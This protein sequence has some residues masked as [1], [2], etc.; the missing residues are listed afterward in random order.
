MVGRPCKLCR[1]R[2]KDNLRLGSIETLGEV[3]VHQN[4]LY[5]SSNLC[6]RGDDDEGIYG[7][8]EDDIKREADRTRF[9]QC[10]FCSKFGA[11]I[12]CCKKSCHKTF[13]TG[14]GYDNGV[15]YQFYGTY[16]AY[17]PKHI[18]MHNFRPGPKEICFIC[19][20]ALA[21]VGE[22][23]SITTMIFSPC[24]GNGWYHRSCL[25]KYA[26]SAGYFFKCPLCNDA[27]KFHDVARWGITIQN[28]DASWELEPGAFRDQAY[29]P[30]SCTAELC[31]YPRGRSVGN[32]KYCCLCGGNPIHNTCN[33]PKSSGT[34]SCRDCNI[35]SSAKP[36]NTTGNETPSD[37]HEDY[38]TMD[39]LVRFSHLLGN[40]NGRDGSLHESIHI[41]G[42]K[43]IAPSTEPSSDEDSPA[44]ST[45]SD[46][47][48]KKSRI[49][50][51]SMETKST[52]SLE[53]NDE[54]DP[55][56]LYF[57]HSNTDSVKKQVPVDDISSDECDPLDMEFPMH[58]MKTK[59]NLNPNKCLIQNKTSS[60]TSYFCGDDNKENIIGSTKL[61]HAQY[62]EQ[63][64]RVQTNKLRPECALHVD[65]E[66]NKAVP[67]I[68]TNGPH[69]STAAQDYERIQRQGTRELRARS[70]TPKVETNPL[71][72]RRGRSRSRA[73]LDMAESSS[74]ED[75]CRTRT[76]IGTPSQMA[77]DS[78][79]TAFRGSHSRTRASLKIPKESAPTG[80]REG[81]SRTITT[82]TIV[83]DS[84]NVDLRKSRSRTRD[85]LKICKD[86]ASIEIHGNRTRA[87][88]PK[89]DERSPPTELRGHR[90]RR[91]P[92]LTIDVD[93]ASNELRR[94]RSRSSTSQ[95]MIRD[96]ASVELRTSRSR[97]TTYRKA[98]HLVSPKERGT[99]SRTS[100][101]CRAS[102]DTS[103]TEA[104]RCRVLKR[105]SGTD[106][107]MGGTRSAVHQQQNR[108]ERLKDIDRLELD[109]SCIANRTRNRAALKEQLKK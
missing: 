63:S 31:V 61:S 92:S 42:K 71:H 85:S 47:K 44:E 30:I 48:P 105:C 26:N 21:M 91:K 35:V 55:L 56:D 5:L 45:D 8:M 49:E 96:S 76:H 75:Q 104:R 93:S 29:R 65:V 54:I 27:S 83:G 33:K 16:R 24:C 88:I 103:S 109:I 9:L 58:V 52:T 90:S 41:A 82:S 7:F 102:E 36:L 70:R 74:S 14:C 62:H 100:T 40:N 18:R 46:K 79:T 50:R 53:S 99:R 67:S 60:S 101:S 4:C 3:L 95:R 51:R 69:H 80:E 68:G 59:D 43:Q 32:L 106:F 6:Q 10:T 23:F 34:Y 98:E 39:S 15:L 19:L 107:N 13:H 86:S 73:F 2:D 94:C 72:L 12:G 81:R 17:C 66:I 78:A 20:E 38:S 25:Q 37:E 28:R 64:Q 57:P 1:S 22:R 87:T 97:I 89:V 108:Y 77:E 84:A 11:N